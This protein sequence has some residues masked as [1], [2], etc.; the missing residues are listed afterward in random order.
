MSRG[1]LGPSFWRLFVSSATSNLADGIGRTALPLLA[2]SL[3]RDPLLISGLVT[4][5]FLPWLLFALLSGVLVDRVDRR[6]A[7][8]AANIFRALVVAALGVAVLVDA[9]GIV[10]LYVAAF[11][12]GAAET[13]YDSAARAMLPAVVNRAQLDRGNSLLVTEEMVGQTFLGAPI[14][15]LLFAMLAAAPLL[16]N[17]VIFVVAAVLILTVRARLP[18]PRTQRST[19]RADVRTGL[20][21]LQAHRLLRGLMLV[22]TAICGIGAMAEAVLVL[23]VLEDLDV[24]SAGFGLFLVAFGIGGLLGGAVAGWLG[25]RLGRIASMVVSNGLGGAAYLVLGVFAQPVLAAVLF[26]VYGLTVIVW[27]VLSMSLRQALIP[28]ELFGRVQGAWRTLVWGVIPVGSL[29]GG[30]LASLTSVRTVFA[31]SG[32]LQLLSAAAVLVVLRPHR[33]ELAA[34]F[35]ADAGAAAEL[36]EVSRQP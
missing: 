14:G 13:V 32:I 34:A 6:K 28:P 4:L 1:G 25:R 12:L 8:A 3:T 18:Q 17:A 36:S 11:L 29:L 15:A 26:G 27:N 10:A 23:Y 33:D 35:A 20:Q 21:W 30:L 7:M 22:T 2:A 9:A 24:P 19:I 31:V 16:G 5:A